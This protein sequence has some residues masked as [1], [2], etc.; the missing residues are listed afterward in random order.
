MTYTLNSVF[1][2]YFTE[3]FYEFAKSHPEYAV[4]FDNYRKDDQPK[5]GTTSGAN[6]AFEDVDT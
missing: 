3:E 6:E 1:Y 2:F 5:K 4:I